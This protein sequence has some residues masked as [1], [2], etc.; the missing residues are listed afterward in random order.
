[1]IVEVDS[2]GSREDGVSSRAREGKRQT[3]TAVATKE[4]SRGSWANRSGF[5]G[6]SAQA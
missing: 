4:N 5:R 3:T 6:D 1:M 2:K